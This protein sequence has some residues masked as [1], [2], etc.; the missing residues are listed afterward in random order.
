MD[1][2]FIAL[3]NILRKII[4]VGLLVIT[5]S[6][7]KIEDEFIENLRSGAFSFAFGIGVGYVL[8]Q[9]IIN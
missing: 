2:D 6:K 3:K 5:I 9:P 4:L 1:G 8:I 7:E